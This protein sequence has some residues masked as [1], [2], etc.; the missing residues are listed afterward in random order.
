MQLFELGPGLKYRGSAGPSGFLKLELRTPSV[1]VAVTSPDLV[2][3]ATN[4][5][6]LAALG[7][8]PP[9]F[10]LTQDDR[11]V[12][13]ADIRGVNPFEYRRHQRG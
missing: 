11:Y 12:G 4:A 6:A 2:A 5:L 10:R 8:P 3:Q 1:W 13:P 7:L 9:G